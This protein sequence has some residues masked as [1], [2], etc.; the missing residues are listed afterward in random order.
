MKTIPITVK[1]ITFF[2]LVL[3][4]SRVFVAAGPSAGTVVGWGANVSGNVTGVPYPGFSTGAV[5]IAEL[6]LTN[7]I[8]IAAGDQHALAL[9]SDGTVRGW[10]ANSRGQALGSPSTYP[11]RAAGVVTINGQIL[12]NV[13][14]IAA[15]WIHS[16]AILNNGTMVGWGTEFDGGNIEVPGGLSNVVSIA[17]WYSLIAKSDGSVVAWGRGNQHTISGLTNIVTV[18]APRSDHGPLVALQKDGTVVESTLAN[19]PVLSIVVSTATAISAGRWQ[20]LALKSDG[21]VFAW[22]NDKSVPVGLS[23]VVA[24]SAGENHSLALKNDGSVIAWGPTTRLALGV[25]AGLSN[26]IAIAAG[27]DFSLAITTNAAVAEHF[28]RK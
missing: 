25:P 24:I 4:L 10:G 17:G 8:A 6:S 5:A 21:T 20:K 3:S 12:S 13:V 19:P 16:H 18:S 2:C 15:G 27:N 1:P 11:G 28:M 23:N 14:A 22:G 26:V 9:C 7:A